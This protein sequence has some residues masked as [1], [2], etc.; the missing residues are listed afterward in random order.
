MVK[1]LVPRLLAAIVLVTAGCSGEPWNNPYPR[2]E[3]DRPI[4]Y[5][6]FQERPKHL[7]PVSSYSENEAIFT[8]QIYEP[9][10]QYHFLKRPFELVPLTATEVPAPQ[11]FDAEGRALPADAPDEA[12]ARVVYRVSLKPGIM[13]QPHPAFARRADGSYRYH[14]LGEADLAEVRTLADFPETGT[15][16]LTADDYVHQM[17]RLVHPD[18]HSPIASLMSRYIAGLEPLARELAAVR[19]ARAGYID[20][21][22]HVLSG[23]RVLDSHRFEIELTEKYPQFVYWLAMSFFA[24]VPWEAD[25]FYGQPGMAARNLTLDWYPIGTGPYLLAENNPN[26]RMVLRRNPS[27]RGEPYPGEGEAGDRERGW[28]ADAGRAMP[29]IDEAHFILEKE[30]IPEWTKFLQGYYDASGIAPDGFDQAIRFAPD[31]TPELT[32]AMREKRIR[33]AVSTR[34]TVSYLGF[35]M[36]DPVV[37]GDGERAR[38]LRQAISIAVDYEEMISIFAN[39]R[40]EVAHG[41]IPPGIFGHEPGEAGINPVVY[42]WA[43]G[44]ARRKPL[45]AAEALLAEAG[46][47]G[48]RDAATGRPLVLYFDA[49]TAGPDSKALLSWYR[50]QFARLGIE[51]VIRA[52]DYNRFQEKMRKGDAQIYGWGWNA[53][54]PD[55]ENFLFLLYGPNAKASAQGENASNYENPRFDELFVTMRGLPNGPERQAVIDEMLTIVREDAPWLFGFHP[56]A[57]SLHHRW[58]GNG[59]PNQMARNSLKYRTVDF[60]LRQELRREWN[61]PRVWPLALGAA[62]LAASATP[63]WLSYRRRRLARAI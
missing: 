20:L 19:A 54:Y 36:L 9:V 7:D 47:P 6:T 17:K 25:A 30:D 51:L 11:Y 50:K 35:N 8:G 41:P 22:E 26:R 18:L 61:A 60:A 45:A 24:P 31:G 2:A 29:F 38:R 27:F 59:K 55:P 21:R 39:G 3:R 63:A 37:G 57:Y 52:T 34:P 40:G 5:S 12:V 13:F 33:L 16:E 23:V 4:F 44:R 32:P 43:D 48:G 1:R 58:Y 62:L 53:D 46:Y 28:L 15:R 14:G 10:V 56:R 42:D 49:I